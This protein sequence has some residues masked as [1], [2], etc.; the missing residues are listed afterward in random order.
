MPHGKALISL[1]ASCE[2]IQVLHSILLRLSLLCTHIC[3]D[4]EAFKFLSLDSLLMRARENVFLCVSLIF[5]ALTTGFQFIADPQFPL[6]NNESGKKTV[7]P[8]FRQKSLS[9]SF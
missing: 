3:H 8:C 1:Q 2:R 7:K 5:E 4:F 6:Y 9:Y